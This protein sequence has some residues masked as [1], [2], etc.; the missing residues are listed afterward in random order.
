M[1]ALIPALAARTIGRLNSTHRMRAIP[2]CCRGAAVSPNQASF[3]TFT[4]QPAP[5]RTLSRMIPGKSAS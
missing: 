1:I 4:S 3:V 5:A 2:R